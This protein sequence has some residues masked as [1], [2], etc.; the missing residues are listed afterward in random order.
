MSV[1]D[2]MGLHENDRASASVE[3]RLEQLAALAFAAADVLFEVDRA[4][5]IRHVGGAIQKLTGH[6]ARSVR[7]MSLF[8]MLIPSDR[9][10]LKRVV[11]AFD[12]GKPVSRTAVRFLRGES[13]NT[14]AMLGMTVMPGSVGERLVTATILDR[15][16]APAP[17]EDG[18]LDRSAF[19]GVAKQLVSTGGEKAQFNLVMLALPQ[20]VSGTAMQD[21]ALG[22]AF[23]AEIEAVLRFSSENG[24]VTRLG[25]GAFAYF[26]KVEDDPGLVAEKIAEVAEVPLTRPCVQKLLLDAM[27]M[28]HKEIEK[29]LNHALETFADEKTRQI[30]AFE[31]LPDCLAAANNRDRGMV[32]SCRDIIRDETF[33]QV[34]QPI[35]TLKNGI[36]QHYEV[37]TRFAEGVARG[38][39][40]TGD[41]IQIAEQIGMINTF[42]LLNCVKTIKLLQLLPNEIKLALNVSGR[43]VQ[44]PEF[45]SQMMNLLDSAEMK[46]SPSRLLIEITET[47][48]IT[49]FQQA[50]SLLQWLV[51]RGHRI[52]LDDFGA[53][54]MS[55]EYLRRFPVDFVKIDGHFFRNAMTSGRD[56]ILIRAIARCSFELGC[57]TVAEMI[58]TE[59]DAALAKE[60]GVECGQ[61]WLF[62]QP[63]TAEQL[64]ASVERVT[65]PQGRAG[66]TGFPL[67]RTVSL[68]PQ[69]GDGDNGS[70]PVLKARPPQK[71]MTARDNL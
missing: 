3:R 60:L 21:T 71:K 50:T 13:E 28:E 1:S 39:A 5:R 27:L 63:V 43:S 35:L 25:D 26:Q 42:D 31:N 23:Y 30:I 34:L 44:S 48:G 47:R 51:K 55:F 65:R 9:I 2:Q 24:V 49:N 33:F 52:C 11:E 32:T 54:A 53:G 66:S 7:N 22:R 17:S 46:I 36:I 70:S 45:A 18:F 16:F 61:G 14:V 29:A 68:S 58:E 10:F 62:G 19:L 69:R 4:F 38:I 6:S 37:L 59:V 57:R 40:N 20:A 64:L 15:G 8:D 41:F 67:S 12:Q 56:R